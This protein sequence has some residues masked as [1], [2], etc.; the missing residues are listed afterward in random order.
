MQNLLEP[1]NLPALREEI[2]Q[3]P[4][5]QPALLLEKIKA[6]SDAFAGREFKIARHLH[7]LQATLFT[8]EE[9]NA[10]N[11]KDI[12][13]KLFYLLDLIKQI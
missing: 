11:F 5:D 9:K 6:V 7:E 10:D 4:D 13:G 2:N 3:I 1:K 8:G 12:R